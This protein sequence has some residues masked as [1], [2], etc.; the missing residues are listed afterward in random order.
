MILYADILNIGPKLVNAL[1]IR[2]MTALIKFSFGFWTKPKCGNDVTFTHNYITHAK[3]KPSH[4][5]S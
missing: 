4:L 3:I 2:I 5:H 1:N